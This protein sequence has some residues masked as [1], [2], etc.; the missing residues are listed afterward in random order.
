LFAIV[1]Q[2]AAL[3]DVGETFSAS[4]IAIDGILVMRYSLSA[5]LSRSF[6]TVRDHS[7]S[8]P[9][10]AAHPRPNLNTD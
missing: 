10:R 1:L 5:Q 2:G 6:P 4:E 7:A 8:N 3:Q 9:G